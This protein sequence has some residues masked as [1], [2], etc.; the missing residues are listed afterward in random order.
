MSLFQKIIGFLFFA[1]FANSIVAQSENPRGTWTLPE[2]VEY[3]LDNNIQI[4]QAKIDQKIALNSKQN[5]FAD[6]FPSVDANARYFWNSGLNIDPVTNAPTRNTIRTFNAGLNGSWILFDGGR[7]WNS[8]N[9]N[10]LQYLSSLYSTEDIENDTKLSVASLFLQILLNREILQVAQE[11]KRVTDLQVNRTQKLVDAGSRPLG[12]VLQLKSQLA[13]DEQAEIAAQNSLT[14]SK[15]QLANIMQLPNPND[16]EITA[17]NIE[18]PDAET[19]ARSPEGIFNTALENQ[20]DIKSAAAN[21]EGSE[22]GVDATRGSFFPTLSLQG[23]VGTN[24][25][26]QIQQFFPEQD[27]GTQ[28]DDNLNQYVGFGLNVPIFT[29]LQNRTLYQNSKLN[30]QRAQLNLELVKNNLRQT[31]YQ[32][33]ADAKASYNSYLA[34]EKA[35]ESS[36]ESFKYADQRF[37]VGALNQFDYENAKNSLAIAKSEMLRAKYDYIFKIKVL[38][39]YLTNQVTL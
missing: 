1:L 31:I 20:P 28:L 16:F 25:S 35:V 23:G 5:S 13:R 29:R 11:Q 14:L 4:Q 27:F 37:Q 38:E 17:P 18:L 33:H 32:A 36:E 10:N 39:F 3:A 8:L 26:S 21:V 2:C 22:E 30:L 19:L 15:L 6:F 34:A 7:N 9:Q 24:Y 12:D